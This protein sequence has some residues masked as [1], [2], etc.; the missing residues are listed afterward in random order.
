MILS[1]LE[2][3]T[4]ADGVFESTRSQAHVYR[5]VVSG[6]VDNVLKG[7]NACVLCYGPRL[8]RSHGPARTSAGTL[9]ETQPGPG[10]LSS[11]PAL[12]LLLQLAAIAEHQLRLRYTTCAMES[13]LLHR[14]FVLRF[15]F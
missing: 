14:R 15:L 4:Q 2:C 5:V 10:Q 9:A 1:M 7:I 12:W 13:S 11:W 3:E 6:L 8:R